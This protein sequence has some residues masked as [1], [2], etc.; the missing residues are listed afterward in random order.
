MFKKEDRE[1]VKSKLQMMQSNPGKVNV[2]A[3]RLHAQGVQQSVDNAVSQKDFYLHK[4]LVPIRSEVIPD[5]VKK[6]KTNFI[7]RVFQKHASVFAGWKSDTKAQVKKMVDIDYSVMKVEKI[8][9]TD[10]E[11]H[12]FK[13]IPCQNIQLL[14][15]LHLGLLGSSD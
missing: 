14:Q 4:C 13:N 3:Q 1:F 15:E 2:L 11:V 8:L 6:V 5:L 9:K 10:K 7:V 12:G